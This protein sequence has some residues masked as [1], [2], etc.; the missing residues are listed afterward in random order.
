M[1]FEYI[2]PPD[3][4]GGCPGQA[5]LLLVIEEPVCCDGQAQLQGVM[6]WMVGLC[7]T[8]SLSLNLNLTTRSTTPCKVCQG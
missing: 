2:P 7:S 3:V 8:R 4:P 1:V 5:G 6:M